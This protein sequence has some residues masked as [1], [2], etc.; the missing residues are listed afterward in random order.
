MFVVELIMMSTV[1]E[2]TGLG[3]QNMLTVRL[4]TSYVPSL[5]AASSSENEYLVPKV[6]NS[7][8]VE[9]MRHYS[10]SK[11]SI[12]SNVSQKVSHIPAE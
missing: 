3:A 6:F 10:N 4:Q 8:H 5:T 11:H 9:S 2:N 12:K 1:T 7:L